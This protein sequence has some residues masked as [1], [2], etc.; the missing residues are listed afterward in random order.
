MH[1]KRNFYI[2]YLQ[3]SMYLFYYIIYQK[4]YQ[5]R[6]R[7]KLQKY[8]EHNIRHFYNIFLCI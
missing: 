7:R 6:R 5:H 1:Y 3:N 2:I 8:D 4:L